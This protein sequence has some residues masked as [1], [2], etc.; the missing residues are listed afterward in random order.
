[1]LDICSEQIYSEDFYAEIF[2]NLLKEKNFQ[3]ELTCPEVLSI[4]SY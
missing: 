1:M 2:L 4:F 3:V